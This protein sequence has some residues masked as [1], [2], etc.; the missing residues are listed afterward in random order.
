M[1]PATVVC[2]CCE[3]TF[4]EV[5]SAIQEGA[6]SI[7][8][9]KRRTRA[10]MGLC[11]GKTCGPIIQRILT[12][13]TGQQASPRLPSARMPVRPVPLDAV[14]GFGKPQGDA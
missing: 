4:A 8:E 5:L 2:R 11:Q 7:D 9:V 1:D 13:V 10:G 12:S 6:T 14:V 3:V